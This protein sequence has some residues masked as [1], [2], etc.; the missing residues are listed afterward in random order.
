MK[1]LEKELEDLRASRVPAPLEEAPAPP[2]PSPDTPEA[3]AVEVPA[4]A[5]E[6]SEVAFRRSLR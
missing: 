6:R 2:L 1:E 4:L 5:G 3:P